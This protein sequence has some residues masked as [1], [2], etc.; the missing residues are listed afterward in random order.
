MLTVKKAE[1]PGFDAVFTNERFKCAFITK[2]AQY[3]F[4][5]VTEM[6]RHNETDEIFVLLKGEAVMLTMED[7]YFTETPLSEGFAYNVSRGTW[8]YLAL[9][10][11]AEVFVAENADTTNQNSDVLTLD[12]EYELKRV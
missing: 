11:D 8:H 7:G 5:P 10:A 1:K 3:S 2:S 6:K 9:S 4:G 12:A